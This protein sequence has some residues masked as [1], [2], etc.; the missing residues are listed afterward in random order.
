MPGESEERR[1][2]EAAPMRAQRHEAVGQLV[3]GVAHAFNNL[4]TTTIGSLELLHI[5]ALEGA[6]RRHIER[7]MQAAVQAGTL[8]N[9]LLAFAGQQ[10]LAPRPVD[11]NTVL[12]RRPRTTESHEA[13]RP[14]TSVL[15]IP[16]RAGTR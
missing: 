1:R 8:T 10:Q 11:A 15:G 5:D 9:K 16:A 6:P 12:R 14:L 13:A 7:A 4:L 2:A 3:A